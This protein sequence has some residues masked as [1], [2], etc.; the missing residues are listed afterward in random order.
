V[1]S[2]FEPRFG[3]DF[4]ALRIHTGDAA[5]ESARALGAK[6]FTMG[7]DIVFGEGQFAPESSEGRELL[8][9]EMVHTLQQSADAGPVVR[10]DALDPANPSAW[11]WYGSE[12][13]RDASFL[14][15]VGKAQGT[16]G[17]LVK[18]LGTEAPQTDEE[19]EAIEKQI[20]TLIR[21][22]AVAMVGAHRAQLAERKRQFQQMAL[23]P[24]AEQQQ[25][26]EG[27]PNDPAA[28]TAKAIRGAAQ[29]AI[30]L[31]ADKE[32][33][34]SLRDDSTA[35][36]RVNAGPETIAGEFQKLSSNAQQYTTSAILAS[37]EATRNSLHSGGLAW[38]SKKVVLL[39]LAAEVHKLREKQINGIDISLTVLYDGFPFLAD[40]EAS[41]ITTGKKH[42]K[43]TAGILGAGTLLLPV[44]AP[45]AAYVGMDAF[46]ADKPLDDQT[47]L[48]EVQ[49]SFDRL[50][51]RT[52]EA[53]VKVGSGSINPLD[54]PGAIAAA[55]G[56]LPAPLQK[57]LDRMKQDHEVFKFATEMALALGVAVLSGV[58]A[59][60]AGVGLAALAAAGGIATA[61]IG[62][63]QLGMQAKDLMDRRALAAAS[64]SPDGQL[65]GVS[66][67]SMFEWAMLAV[68]AALTAADLAV[69]A[70]QI[71]GLRPSFSQEPH[72]SLGK[73][74]PGPPKAEGEPSAPRTEGEPVAP[75]PEAEGAPSGAP[76]GE[77]TGGAANP[78]EQKMLELGRGD[79]P[80]SR[81]QIDAEMAVVRRT[82]PRKL[83]GGPYVEE[84]E[85]PN[86]HTWR[87]DANGSWCRFSN[88]EVCVPGTPDAAGTPTT[89]AGTVTP[90]EAAEPQPGVE[91]PVAEPTDPV[92]VPAGTPLKPGQNPRIVGELPPGEVRSV[93]ELA[94][95]RT[96]FKNNKQR[97]RE[98]WEQRNGRPWPTDPATGLP[99]RA[100]HEPRSLANGGD[101]HRIEP[102]FGDPNAEHMVPDP[103][104]GLTEQQV[105]GGRRRNQPAKRPAT[106]GPKPSENPR[107]VGE[108]PPGEMRTVEEVEQTRNW[109][110]NNK[111]QLREEWE[112]R[113][114]RPWPTDPATGMPARASH[115]PRSLA[116]GGDPRVFE[117]RFGSPN[118]EHMIPD[119]ETGLT[120]QQVFGGRRRKP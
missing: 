28:D 109:F 52:D 92:A 106:T 29:T 93:E 89:P 26:G 58:T 38:G 110:K 49:A 63:A 13:H 35:T 14:E 96:W 43:T 19:R 36:V 32:R 18:Q 47:L 71:G 76:K 105:F 98:E 116:K 104:T 30:E 44:L 85:L 67:P 23:K 65:L 78:A 45:L 51:V 20:L 21:L 113:N 8:A 59:G 27:S 3:R 115:E 107:I 39:S 100:S 88:G 94:Q 4:S 117:P 72:P 9:H 114:G 6:A 80:P 120:E 91:A 97:L 101:P 53:I 84:V 64:T 103:E 25:E 69:L 16:A 82:E 70:K 87:R 86:G 108:L 95:T 112:K 62:I 50:L 55:R 74:E 15:T 5:A 2:F 48:A 37:V 66:A 83:S 1:R 90:A 60:A 57:E 40:L 42:S 119:P 75:R 24:P 99:A 33:L 102:R 56:A 118:T 41:Y 77:G 54:L 31:N 68:S 11:D 7:R 34:S 10:R 46:K 12:S 81:A 22:H 111:Q 73:G 61:G 17:T 79:A